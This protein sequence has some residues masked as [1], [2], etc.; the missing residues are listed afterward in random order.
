[1]V[2]LRKINLKRK[3][4]KYPLLV[5]PVAS[6]TEI[7]LVPIYTAKF[8]VAERNNLSSNC[9]D[10]EPFKTPSIFSPCDI[11]G[12]SRENGRSTLAHT[13]ISRQSHLRNLSELII[14]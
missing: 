12:T 6:K 7:Q 8:K 9:T 4:W 13:Y 10:C 11:L 3:Q 5:S 1:M 14:S 2:V